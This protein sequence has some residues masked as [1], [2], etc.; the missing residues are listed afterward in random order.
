[1]LDALGRDQ[2]CYG[3]LR[4]RHGSGLSL[5]SV[6]KDTA[7]LLLTLQEFSALPQYAVSELGDQRDRFIAKMILDGILEIEVGERALTGPSA[8]NVVAGTDA[9]PEPMGT[10]ARL[11]MKAIEYADALDLLDPVPIA[12]RLYTFNAIPV[13]ARWKRLLCDQAAV[14]NYLRVFESSV[15][16]MLQT[17][18]SLISQP[19]ESWKS[20]RSERIRTYPTN[21]IVYKLYVSPH[22]CDLPLAFGTVVERLSRSQSFQW[23]VGAN[24]YG[25]LRPDKIVA[26]FEEIADLRETAAELYAAL[27]GCAE[28]GVPFTAELGA[29]AL[30]S[31]GVDPVTEDRSVPWLQRESWR[32]RICNRLAS[33]LVTARMATGGNSRP[34]FAVE[35]L[36]LDGIDTRTWTP[37]P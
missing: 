18:W 16:R 34:H 36:A 8:L 33:A 21:S 2:D 13:S 5:K 32:S 10:L 30:L 14:D 17:N 31:W 12:A 28:H 25:L 24:I 20:W 9:M 19:V 27:L 15:A 26:Y 37:A 23:K 4:P 1:M 11:S 29:A 6:S 22:P 35:R 7:L 3:I